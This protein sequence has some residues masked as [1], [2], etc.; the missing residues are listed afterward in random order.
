MSCYYFLKFAFTYPNG[1]MLHF[2]HGGSF[3]RHIYWMFG[4]VLEAYSYLGKQFN[5]FC[6]IGLVVACVK[7]DTA[8]I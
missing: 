6:F 4:R 1:L 8:F 3:W 2:I 7:I 5:F